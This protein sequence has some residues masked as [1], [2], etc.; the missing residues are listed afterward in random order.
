[1]LTEAFP[2]LKRTV[3]CRLD[4]NEIN[5]DFYLFLLSITSS[6]TRGGRLMS[7]I[8]WPREALDIKLL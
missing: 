4:S 8:W 1:M 5:N 3:I 7:C 2:A 6:E